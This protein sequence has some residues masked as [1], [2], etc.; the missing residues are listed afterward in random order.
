MANPPRGNHQG[1]SKSNSGSPNISNEFEFDGNKVPITSNTII[2]ATQM[3][4]ITYGQIP[5]WN[6]IPVHTFGHGSV[7]GNGD[8]THLT[9]DVE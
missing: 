4:V 6:Q 3:Y 5:N 1:V 2:S 9:L 8:L 7:D